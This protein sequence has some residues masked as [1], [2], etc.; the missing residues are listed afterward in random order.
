MIEWSF[1]TSIFAT[2]SKKANSQE[3]QDRIMD[4]ESYGNQKY[5][6]LF[7]LDL[8]VGIATDGIK[9]RLYIES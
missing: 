1:D 8:H 7:A 6:Y 2:T 4:S 5:F 9:E 3:L